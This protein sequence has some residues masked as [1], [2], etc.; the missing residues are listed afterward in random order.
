MFM[1]KE[2]ISGITNNLIFNLLPDNLQN[3]SQF[4]FGNE[5]RG[6]NGISDRGRSSVTAIA[7][8]AAAAARVEKTVREN[9]GAM[10]RGMTTTAETFA[11]AID[12]WHSTADLDT[13]TEE[14]L[15]RER[16]SGNNSLKIGEYAVADTTTTTT[17]ATTFVD[18]TIDWGRSTVAGATAANAAKT[19]LIT[20]ATYSNDVL[21]EG[22][23]EIIDQK[24]VV[25]PVLAVALTDGS[26]NIVIQGNDGDDNITEYVTTATTTINSNVETLDKKRFKVLPL[27]AAVDIEEHNE[28]VLSNI[29]N[30][31]YKDSSINIGGS[32]SSSSGSGSSSR[33]STSAIITKDVKIRQRRQ[34][35][36]GHKVDDDYLEHCSE[37]EEEENEEE[38]KKDEEH[39]TIRNGNN[40]KQ[41]SDIYTDDKKKKKVS[42][43]NRVGGIY[44]LDDTHVRNGY[45]GISEI[46][47]CAGEM[48]PIGNETE[49]GISSI[50]QSNH[51]S[52]SNRLSNA[53]DSV[54]NGSNH[55]HG[56][57]FNGDIN[58]NNNNN[59]NANHVHG[60]TF[61]RD[62]NINQLHG[63][64][65]NRDINNNNNN[66]EGVDISVAKNSQTSHSTNSHD[67]LESINNRM[68]MFLEE[69]PEST[70]KKAD[71][72][73][74]L[75]I[76]VVPERKRQRKRKQQ[77][78]PFDD[79]TT[80]YDPS[81]FDTDNSH[82]KIRRREV[83][84][85]E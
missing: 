42:P 43:V 40:Y 65:F 20:P 54:N 50:M 61:N 34:T 37:S 19:V 57:S 48:R 75:P 2:S 53:S 1:L 18:E 41:K 27:P 32:N 24:Q 14:V 15:D 70:H 9:K 8:A 66:D 47:T 63:S 68:R 5:A 80:M 73:S 45:L 56:S 67:T 60:S 71:D 38:G 33:S 81:S 30:K 85:T 12:D 72:Q 82:F 69:T 28:N 58:N 35:I 17:T 83:S 51:Y 59:N 23:D 79:F 46:E 4:T 49:T 62:N 74:S 64:N 3:L 21:I 13:V 16:Y 29:N 6:S 26:D 22:D 76:I 36:L 44:A 78:Q 25:S 84:A 39:D 77:Q 55:L 11:S 52:D 10:E 31:H 7:E